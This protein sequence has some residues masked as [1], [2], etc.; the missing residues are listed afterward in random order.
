MR[1]QE[2]E[3]LRRLE[4]ELMATEY[5]E[6]DLMDEIEILDDTWLDFMDFPD[7]VYNSDDTDVDLET[8]SEEVHQGNNRGPSSA[9]LVTLIIILSL[10][11]VFSLLKILGV[12]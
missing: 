1:K 8:Y 7:C 10:V 11:V 9:L 3:E 2:Q 4:E 6:E 12:V 5:T